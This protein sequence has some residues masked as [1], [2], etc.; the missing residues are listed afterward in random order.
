VG[1]C[2]ALGMVPWYPNQGRGALEGPQGGLAGVYHAENLTF[3]EV[4]EGGPDRG[5]APSG[6]E[7]AP[8]RG[9]KRRGK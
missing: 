6:T 2:L 3:G 1:W 9:G 5:E 4:R 8:F 7:K